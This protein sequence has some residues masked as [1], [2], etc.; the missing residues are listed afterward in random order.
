MLTPEE[1]RK[2]AEECEQLARMGPPDKAD[3]MLAIANAWR[4]LAEEAQQ[5]QGSPSPI[6]P[7]PAS[8][9]K[10]SHALPRRGP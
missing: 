7:A 5:R 4:G 2:Y 3:I 9:P 6:T 8:S 1:Y 10:A